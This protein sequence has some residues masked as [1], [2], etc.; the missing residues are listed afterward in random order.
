MIDVEVKVLVTV[1]VQRGR[2]KKVEQKL[3]AGGKAARGRMSA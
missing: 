3:C 2:G 1:E